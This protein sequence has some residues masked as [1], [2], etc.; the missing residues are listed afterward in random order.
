MMQAA[1][2]LRKERMLQEVMELA[3]KH[4]TIAVASLKK[5]RASQLSELRKKFR[6]ELTIKVFKNRIAAMGLK[7]LKKPNLDELAERLKDQVALIFTDLD[8]FELSIRL[9]RSKIDLP[10]KAGDIATDDVV[11]PAGNTGIPPGPVL[12]DFKLLGIPTKI[13][14]GNIMVTKD[15]TVVRK[16]EVISQKLASLLT[17]LGIKPIKAGLSIKLAYSD[18]ML[19]TEEELKVDLAEYEEKVSRAHRDA[20]SLAVQAG[21]PAPEVLPMVVAK[22][23]R[24]AMSLAC[25]CGYTSPET[26]VQVLCAAEAKARSLYR[27]LSE[28]G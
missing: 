8:P 3:S 19:F 26:I 20:I 28:Q 22:A 21:Y 15:T 6:G 4:R 14:M 13:D 25:S 17:R 1:S 2:R 23:H 24:E 10:A 11:I 18:G 27:V 7:R 9:E 5:V 16:G 12:S